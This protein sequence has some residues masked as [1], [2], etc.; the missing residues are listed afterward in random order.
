MFPSGRSWSRAARSSRP[1]FV[2]KSCRAVPRSR[3]SRTSGGG[4]ATQSPVTLLFSVVTA[5]ARART[6][7][8]YRQ[9]QWG[10]RVRDRPSSH[11]PSGRPR[12]LHNQLTAGVDALSELSEL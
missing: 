12:A 2:A 8:I 4:G 6:H 3:G 5:R 11:L 7:G 10:S 9:G 1:Y